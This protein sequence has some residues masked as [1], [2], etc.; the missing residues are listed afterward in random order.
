MLP[1]TYW[2]RQLALLNGVGHTSTIREMDR[3]LA[4]AKSG[5]QVALQASGSNPDTRVPLPRGGF[6]R[7]ILFASPCAGDRP[8][9]VHARSAAASQS[10]VR[11]GSGQVGRGPPQPPSCPGNGVKLKSGVERMAS[12]PPKPLIRASWSAKT[13]RSASSGSTMFRSSP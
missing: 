11:G 5:I 1:A 4:V 10:L 6:V 3:D 7:V 9:D 2:R 13:R 12:A 8:D